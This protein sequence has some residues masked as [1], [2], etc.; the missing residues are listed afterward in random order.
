MET[1]KRV[2]LIL[3]NGESYD[4]DSSHCSVVLNEIVENVSNLGGRLFK[5]RVANKVNIVFNNV[6][7]NDWLNSIVEQ[8]NI[9]EVILID[10]PGSSEKYYVKWGETDIDENSLQSTYRNSNKQV[11]VMINN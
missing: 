8:K 6:I 11:V 4:F 5:T 9:L 2:E 1:V 3:E 7:D 10:H